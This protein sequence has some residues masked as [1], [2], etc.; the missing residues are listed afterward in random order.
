MF[1]LFAECM[2]NA[3]TLRSLG[4]QCLHRH[5][6]QLH[7]LVDEALRVNMSVLLASQWL[8]VRLQLLGVAITVTIAASLV[9]NAMYRGLPI[10]PGLAGLS[11]IYS[12]SIVTTL[13]GLVGSL[14]ETEQEMVSVERVMEYVEL[15]SEYHSHQHHHHNHQHGQEEG[16]TRRGWWCC[17]RN[18]MRYV[19]VLQADSDPAAP[20]A[21]TESLLP[22]RPP[23]HEGS[24]EVGRGLYNPAM[25]VQLFHVRL[26]YPGAAGYSLRNISLSIPAGSRVAIIG[27]TGSGKSSLLR[28]LLRLN[29]YESSARVCGSELREIPKATLRKEVVGVVPQSPV[30]FAGMTLRFNIDPFQECSDEAIV[31]SLEKCR[32][33]DSLRAS[34]RGRTGV[35][36]GGAGEE[37]REE[38]RSLLD[39]VIQE[40][41]AEES[42]ASTSS[43]PSLTLSLGQRQLVSLGRAVLRG[44][45]RL[46]LVDEL[47]ASIDL[48]TETLLYQALFDHCQATGT[49]LLIVCHKLH[50][51]RKYCNKV[52]E[53]EDGSVK[54]FKDLP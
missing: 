6:E 5:Q 4:P 14:S 25:C 46:L 48:G 11:F 1:A 53:L 9:L 3:P 22:D 38:L 8:G 18:A 40:E 47:A 32:L 17:Q 31:D 16:R 20:S 23:N 27:R 19:P 12:S 41:A 51:V 45:R 7:D 35:P 39:C 2:S 50:A 36:R 15:P 37:R 42:F 21:I 13:N 29:D 26:K 52:L 33:L 54:S 43:T 44:E 30:L 10:S 28:L 24:T 49:T 34:R